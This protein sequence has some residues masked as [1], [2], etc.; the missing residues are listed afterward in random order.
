MLESGFSEVGSASSAPRGGKALVIGG[1]M[2]GMMAARVLTE[3]FDQVTILDRDHFPTGPTPRKGIPQSRHVH[4]LLMRGL[5]ILEELF[6]GLGAQMSQAGAIELDTADDL[7][8]L[9]PFGWGRRFK[10]GLRKLAFSRDLL[11]WI[12]RSRLSVMPGVDFLTGTDVVGLTPTKDGSCVAGVRVRGR[13]PAAGHEAVLSADLVVDA[14]GRGS[15]MP[16]WLSEAGWE[17]PQEVTVT[18][19]LGYVSR[20]YKAPEP[21][22]EN[23]KA[24][25]VQAAPPTTRRAGVLFPIEDN[26][27]LVTLAGAERDYPPEDPDGYLEFAGS[28]PSPLIHEFMSRAEPLTAPVGF[29]ATQNRRRHYEKLRSM[30]LNLLVIGDA[31]CC[32]NPVY[33]QG[34]TTAAIQVLELRDCLGRSR[35]MNRPAT[36]ARDFHRRLAKAVDGPWAMATSEDCRYPAAEGAKLGRSNRW[37]HAFTDRVVAL[38]VHSES[39]RRTWLEVFHMVKPPSALFHPTVISAVVVSACRDWLVR[40]GSRAKWPFRRDF[41]GSPQTP[42]SDPLV[43]RAAPLPGSAQTEAAGD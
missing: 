32:F 2:A 13:G 8:W 36:L 39:V 35:F 16:V 22:R 1:S 34:I 14:S 41:P 17:A 33:G 18:A 24:V 5:K 7:A 31:A 11:D 25:F 27:F 23:W 15:K 10:S 26:R 3:Y 12:V 43:G 28:L 6:P 30:P 9:T 4:V 19:F 29:R 42:G 20:V 40:I 21:S 38:T 37:M